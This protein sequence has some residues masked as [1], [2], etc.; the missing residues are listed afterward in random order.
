MNSL[1]F[2]QPDIAFISGSNIPA[3]GSGSGG[4]GIS[5]SL[6]EDLGT[7]F[8]CVIVVFEASF[9][10]EAL[11]AARGFGGIVM[12]WSESPRSQSGFWQSA[13]KLPKSRYSFLSLTVSQRIGH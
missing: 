13:I 12:L 4:G 11:R 1:A 8:S 10:M 6:V 3:G 7:S 5:A 2:K 9:A